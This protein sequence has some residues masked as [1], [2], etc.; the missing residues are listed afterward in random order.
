M[1]LNEKALELKR[2]NRAALKGLF[3]MAH[4]NSTVTRDEMHY[5][6]DQALDS[7]RDYV[8]NDS[9]DIGRYGGIAGLV[10]GASTAWALKGGY[11]GVI[12]P[13]AIVGGVAGWTISMFGA[14]LMKDIRDKINGVRYYRDV[15][16]ESW[17]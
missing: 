1:R 9:W 12:T 4:R 10:V 3:E 6:I 7:T 2:T 8:R 15:M 17:D 11:L 16:Q 14:T 13:S 5:F